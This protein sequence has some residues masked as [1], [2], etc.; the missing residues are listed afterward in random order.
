[1][2]SLRE[3]MREDGENLEEAKQ[4]A[5]EIKREEAEEAAGEDRWEDSVGQTMEAT[6]DAAAHV[7]RVG[8]ELAAAAECWADGLPEKEKCT[9]LLGRM[10]AAATALYKAKHLE[11]Q[12]E[13]YTLWGETAFE[14]HALGRLNLRGAPRKQRVQ[15]MIRPAEVGP[16]FPERMLECVRQGLARV[17]GRCGWSERSGGSSEK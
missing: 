3:E 4:V 17:R 6:R 14:P 11:G 10:D 13:H 5:A 7:E 15:K 8:T 2:Q 12:A 9:E 16:H 1:M